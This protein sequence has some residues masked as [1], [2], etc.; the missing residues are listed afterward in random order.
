M[1]HQRRGEHGAGYWGNSGGPLEP[2][3]F[4]QQGAL[5]ELREEAGLDL[6]VGEVRFLGVMNFTQMQPKHY[7][8]RG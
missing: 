6:T 5:R 1:L 4:L 3:E 2:G 8:D 7:V